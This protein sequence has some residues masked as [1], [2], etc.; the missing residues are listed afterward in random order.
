MIGSSV[1]STTRPYFSS[2]RLR[3]L[4]R[5]NT[6]K[7]C[8]STENMTFH[9]STIAP[10]NLHRKTPLYL[11]VAKTCKWLVKSLKHEIL[12]S[13]NHSNTWKFFDEK[14]DFLPS[15]NKLWNPYTLDEYHLICVYEILFPHHWA[16]IDWLIVLGFR[17]SQA[18]M[19]L[20]LKKR[21]FVPHV[22]SW[23]PP[24]AHAVDVLQF[25]EKGAQVHVWA[26]PEL[27]IH[28]ECGPRFPLPLHTFY[29]LDIHQP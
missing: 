3:V 24:Q 5:Q 10:S 19:H 29:T 9:S 27:H 25:Q 28:R 22:K 12:S 16:L 2:W 11:R 1:L 18:P 21:P 17:T 6:R 15:G 8:S 20:D 14:V 7:K 23:E 26:R 4:F 13:L